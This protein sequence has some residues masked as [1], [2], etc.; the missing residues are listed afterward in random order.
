M[1]GKTVRPASPSTPVSTAGK[2]TESS[3]D[4]YGQLVSNATADST[5]QRQRKAPHEKMCS[6]YTVEREDRTNY[7]KKA[8]NVMSDVINKIKEYR[9]SRSP[10]SSVNDCNTSMPLTKPQPIIYTK[11]EAHNADPFVMSKNMLP[12]PFEVLEKSKEEF[13][14]FAK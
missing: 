1:K 12:S 5:F 10:Y 4:N 9:N 6:E 2:F 14:S 11:F 3:K 7:S 13:L 8:Y